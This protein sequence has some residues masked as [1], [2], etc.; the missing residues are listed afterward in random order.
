MEGWGSFASLKISDMQPPAR[1][2]QADNPRHLQSL[3]RMPP[4]AVIKLLRTMPY[5]ERAGGQGSRGLGVHARWGEWAVSQ[6]KFVWG[7]AMPN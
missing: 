5:P 2:L 4:S 3:H 6:K 1:Q 7:P